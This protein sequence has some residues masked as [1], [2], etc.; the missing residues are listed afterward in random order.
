L[1]R[2]FAVLEA[3]VAQLKAQQ[4]YLTKQLASLPKIT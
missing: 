3:L 2:R 4:D 1:I